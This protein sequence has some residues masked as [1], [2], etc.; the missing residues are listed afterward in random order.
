MF[1]NT[2]NGSTQLSAEA[3]AV[4]CKPFKHFNKSPLQVLGYGIIS[5]SLINVEVTGGSNGSRVFFKHTSINP[6]GI[7]QLTLDSYYV[8]SRVSTSVSSVGIRQLA[9]W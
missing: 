3:L 8:A 6:V 4:H 2:K 1:G 7:Q 5:G 9:P